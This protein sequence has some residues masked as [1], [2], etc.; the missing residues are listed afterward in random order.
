[1]TDPLI[2]SINNPS[3]TFKVLD[4]PTSKADDPRVQLSLANQTMQL[5]AA[6]IQKALF[7]LKQAHDLL[8][9]RKGNAFLDK[10]FDLPF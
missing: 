3:G 9:E 5:S 4:L 1:M 2:G 6:E 7:I 10:N 8:T